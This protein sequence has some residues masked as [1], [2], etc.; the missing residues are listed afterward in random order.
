MVIREADVIRCSVMDLAIL[1]MDS[2]AVR[3]AMRED[4]TLLVSGARGTVAT[5]PFGVVRV[6][7]VSTTATPSATDEASDACVTAVCL[8]LARPQPANESAAGRWDRVLRNA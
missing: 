5:G 2:V 7:R 6:D 4:A 8:D 1:G 3:R